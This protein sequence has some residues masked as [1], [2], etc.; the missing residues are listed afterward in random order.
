MAASSSAA[1]TSASAAERRLAEIGV[2]VVMVL[3]A[4]NFIVV[5]SAVAQLPPVGF[6]F[7]RFVLASVTLLLLLRWREGSIGLPRRDLVAILALGAI[8]FGAYQILWTTGLTTVPAGDSALLIAATPVLVALLAVV[9]RTD[10]LTPVKLI[11]ILVSFVGVVIVVGSGPGLTLGRSLVGE[12]LTLAGAVCWSVYTAFGAP[13]V[14]RHSPLRATAWATVAGTVVLA[15]IAVLQ[16]G[17]LDRVPLGLD[18]IGAILY[19]GMLAAGVANVVVLNGVK[20]VGP[21]RTAALQFL[22]PA[23]A[24]LLAFLFLQE[25]IRPGQVVGGLVIVGGVLITRGG[26]P[27]RVIRVDRPRS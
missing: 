16:L 1:S 24:V 25:P 6:T 4:A 10:V 23:L 17:S 8:G 26:L 9:A 12:A 5:K 2:V 15:P 14:R 22:V 19:S 18:V 7:L 11:G 27:F 20:V 21:T 3:W 13:Y